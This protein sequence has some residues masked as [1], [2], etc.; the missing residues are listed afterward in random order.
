MEQCYPF[1]FSP[2]PFPEGI[3]RGQEMH[4]TL[5]LLE[6]TGGFPGKFCDS[7][8][9]GTNNDPISTFLVDIFG[10]IEGNGMGG[11]INRFRQFLFPLFNLSLQGNY[12]VVI[13]MYP[14]HGD[15]PEG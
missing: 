2:V 1:S 8:L 6:K 12:D 11:P 4:F 7:I 10:F 14:I 13:I 3:R 15:R 5:L 9:A